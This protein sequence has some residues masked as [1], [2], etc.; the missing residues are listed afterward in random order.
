MPYRPRFVYMDLDD[1]LAA[2]P[3]ARALGV[4]EVARGAGGFVEQYEDAEG[5]SGRLTEHW[6]R[7]RDGFVARH[8]TQARDNGEPWFD[9]GEP[10]R[11]HLALMMWA[12]TPTPARTQRWLEAL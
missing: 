5:D 9:G 7:K 2:E 10:T 8:V 12:Y 4:S 3:E 11:R 1:V 6:Q